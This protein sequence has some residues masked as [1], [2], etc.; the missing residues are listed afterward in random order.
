[1]SIE[2]WSNPSALVWCACEDEHRTYLRT[3]GDSKD[4]TTYIDNL[5]LSF[6]DSDNRLFYYFT[7]FDFII[8]QKIR[9][10]GFVTLGNISIDNVITMLSNAWL[11]YYERFLKPM[12]YN[13]DVAVIDLDNAKTR[14]F[15][16]CDDVDDKFKKMVYE[17]Y[18]NELRS[19]RIKGE[20]L[21]TLKFY[22]KMNRAQFR[23]LNKIGSINIK[24]KIY[25]N[26]LKSETDPTQD[27]PVS[28]VYDAMMSGNPVDVKMNR[29]SFNGIH[30]DQLS[31]IERRNNDMFDAFNELR[32]IK[33]DLTSK[34]SQIVKYEKS[35]NDEK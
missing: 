14:L 35:L 8:K 2:T 31:T 13:K 18:N 26:P 20:K 29:M 11:P 9:N 7:G 15:G 24:R 19:W 17:M 22:F 10:I 1:M 4:C 33:G 23:E 6:Y 27:C 21:I 5:N 34:V 28:R 12:Q 32:R 30:A 3:F 16:D 25:P